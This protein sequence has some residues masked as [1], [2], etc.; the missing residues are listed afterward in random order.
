MEEN[1]SP[2]SGSTMVRVV[3]VITLKVERSTRAGIDTSALQGA[4]RSGGEYRGIGVSGE[5]LQDRAARGISRKSQ[6]SNETKNRQ[7]ILYTDGHLAPT[8]CLY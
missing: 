3:T 1:S 6:K 4:G 8:G 5:G 2:V 7:R